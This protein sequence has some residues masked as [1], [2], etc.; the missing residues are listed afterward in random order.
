M[1]K[2]FISLTALFIILTGVLCFVGCK[3]K[4]DDGAPVNDGNE[5]TETGKDDAQ[6]SQ[7]G[8]LA[9]DNGY[10]IEAGGARKFAFFS[11]YAGKY[12]FDM[13]C[14]ANI[15]VSCGAESLD[16]AENFFSKELAAGEKFEFEAHNGGSETVTGNVSV[17][18]AKVSDNKISFNSDVN[19]SYILKFSPKESAMYDING[20][21]GLLVCD[22]RSATST[23]ALVRIDM[24]GETEYT[25]AACAQFFLNGDSDYYI[26]AQRTRDA[27]GECEIVFS[28]TETALANGNPADLDSNGNYKFYKYAY[29]GVSR[30]DLKIAF[31]NITG[32]KDV[33]KG[34]VFDE[35]GEKLPA[36]SFS[37]GEI[38]INNVK[39]GDVY[40][41]GI[42]L[43]SDATFTFTT[44][45][46]IVAEKARFEWKIRKG[47]EE[48][49][50]GAANVA[51]LEVNATYGFELWFYGDGEGKKIFPIDIVSGELTG[52][53]IDND[54]G[55]VTI[56]AERVQGDAFTLGGMSTDYSFY[57]YTLTVIPI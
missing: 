57:F 49:P 9:P 55:R 36:A 53:V 4:T 52:L 8:L 20:S 21:T 26:I 56:D 50:V 33:F 29:S 47:D 22:I 2:I 10:V 6:I 28:Q 45:P 44:T 17:D 31:D 46:Q 3:G 54:T 15:E 12:T 13:D 19:E 7:I 1:K 16:I 40:Y 34:V 14:S 35:K 38:V 27:K 11:E 43:I 51:K 5:T 18:V 32:E 37:Y 30:Y 48:M 42:K 39:E 41:I 23:G 24:Y 25:P